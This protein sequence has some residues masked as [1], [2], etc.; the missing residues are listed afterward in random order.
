MPF[1]GANVLPTVA[2]KMMDVLGPNGENWM[3]GML[4]NGQGKHCMLGAL[5]IVAGANRPEHMRALERAC[6]VVSHVQGYYL[7]YGSFGQG[8][9]VPVPLF[10]N[11]NPD[12]FR[13][14]KAALEVFKADEL[15]G[16]RRVSEHARKISGLA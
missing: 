6:G 12:G 4:H 14:V 8:E 16:R 11:T 9:A 13:G 10:N 3:R 1:D 15:D 7:G 2:D 5:E